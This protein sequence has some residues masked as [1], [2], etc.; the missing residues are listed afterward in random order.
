MRAEEIRNHLRR[1]PFLP[2]RLYLSNGVSY[3][4]RHPEFMYVGRREVVI[5]VELGEGDVPE[6]SAYCDP[7]H[8]THI[9]PIHGMRG[10]PF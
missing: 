10:Q 5:A 3:E 9:E 1:E 2:F 7:L 8:V 6:R 4:V